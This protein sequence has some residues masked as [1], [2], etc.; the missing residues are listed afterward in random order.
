MEVVR[1]AVDVPLFNG[2]PAGGL[3][4]LGTAM[5]TWEI[6]DTGPSGRIRRHS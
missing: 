2:P 6:L 5:R 4:M 1:L 3:G